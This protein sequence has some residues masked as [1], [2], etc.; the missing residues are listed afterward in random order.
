MS[1]PY[2]LPTKEPDADLT[3]E[4]DLARYLE[5]L[6]LPNRSYQVGE[7][8]RPDKPNG[9]E[10]RCTKPGQTGASRPAWRAEIGAVIED[11]SVEWT[12]VD[13][14]HLATDTIQSATVAFDAGITIESQSH[15]ETR[16]FVQLSGGTDGVEY[17]GELTVTF[18]TGETEVFDLVIAVE[19]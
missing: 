12:T 14:D 15:Q 19:E 8:V 17:A 5:R 1:T 3:Y 13:F 18:N 2:R 9:Y 6:W 10:Y 7:Y 4:I 11:G 16:V